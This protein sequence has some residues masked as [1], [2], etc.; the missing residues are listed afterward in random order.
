MSVL[1]GLNDKCRDDHMKF[2]SGNYGEART[3]PH[4]SRSR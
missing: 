3:L 4:P 2:Y 1:L